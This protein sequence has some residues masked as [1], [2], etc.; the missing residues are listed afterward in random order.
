MRSLKYKWFAH[1]YMAK[2]WE[3][4]DFNPERLSAAGAFS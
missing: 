2:K 4:G 3:E 1:G